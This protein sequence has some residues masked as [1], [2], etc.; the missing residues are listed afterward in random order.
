MACI[1]FTALMLERRMHRINEVSY[2]LAP[3]GIVGS[4]AGGADSARADFGTA[5][6]LLVIIGVMVFAAGLSYR[7]RHCGA[8]LAG[9]PALLACGDDGS[10]TGATACWRFSIPGRIRRTTGFQIIQS[11]IAVGTGGIFGRG[12][13]DSIQKMFFLPEPHTD[14]IFS[15]IGEELGLIGATGGHWCASA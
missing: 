7:Y 12:S 13:V 14:F 4:A 8:G 6:S 10:R 15:V 5:L 2:S 11:F 9:D 1:L 3:I